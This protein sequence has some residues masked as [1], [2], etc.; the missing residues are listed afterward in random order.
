M[1]ILH[2]LASLFRP[3][4]I[5][6]ASPVK[7][8]IY[9]FNP[10]RTSDIGLSQMLMGTHASSQMFMSTFARSQVFMGTHARYL[11]TVRSELTWKLVSVPINI[12]NRAYAYP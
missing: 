4:K 10:R 1:T 7:Y 2:T 3:S 9:Y 11:Y 5:G 8:N 6:F 12:C